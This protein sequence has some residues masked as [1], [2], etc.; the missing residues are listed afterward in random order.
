MHKTYIM[1]SRNN[2]TNGNLFRLLIAFED[3]NLDRSYLARSS[4]PN[5][6]GELNRIGYEQR[7]STIHLTPTEFNRLVKQYNPT[8]EN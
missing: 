6:A 8:Y 1:F 3:G 7:L 2:D 4:S 5:I